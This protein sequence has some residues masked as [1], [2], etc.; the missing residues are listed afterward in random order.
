MDWEVE[1]YQ[2]EN[3]DIP[4]LDFLLSLNPKKHDYETRCE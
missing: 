3:G 2:R 4:V 1:Y